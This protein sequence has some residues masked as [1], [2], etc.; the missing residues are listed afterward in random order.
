MSMH[1]RKGGKFMKLKKKSGLISAVIALSCASLVSVGFASWVISQGD[2]RDVEGQIIVDTVDDQ[3]HLITVNT[4]DIPAIK[5]VSNSTSTESKWLTSDRS[6]ANLTASISITVTNLDS[7]SK[8][9]ATLVSGTGTGSSFVADTA[10]NGYLGAY[11]DGYV[12][13]LPTPSLGTGAANASEST[14]WDVTI[15]LTFTWG[16]YFNSQNPFDFYNA[17]TANEARDDAKHS[18]DDYAQDAASSLDA[19]E[20]YLTGVKYKL[21]IT[22]AA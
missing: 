2:S 22:V 13:Q 10:G 17:H 16:S 7:N 15:S 21:T 3:R 14:S 1:I 18:G 9:S 11:A 19:L 4:V 20:T 12:G 5:F 6:D 8:I